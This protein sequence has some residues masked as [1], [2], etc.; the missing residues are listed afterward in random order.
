MERH[1]ANLDRVNIVQIIRDNY[2]ELN[3]TNKKIADFILQNLEMATFSPLLE[4]SKEIGVSDTSLIRFSRELGFKGYQDLRE[5][6]VDHIRKIIYPTLK[7]SI[8]GEQGQHP[9]IDVVMKKDMEYITKTMT[10]IDEK[11]FDSL[12]EFIM[13]AKRVFCMG[14]A[15]S[16]FLA[17]YLA[18]IL[19]FLSFE[20]IPV[21]RERRPMIQQILFM[22]KDDILIAFDLLPYAAEVLEAIEYIR[23]KDRDIRIVTI[24]NDPL[25]HIVQYSDLSFFCDMSGHEF[26]LASLTAPMCL[27]NAIMEQIA[28]KKPK[29]VNEAFD[30]FQRAIMSSPLHYAQFDPQNF[31]WRISRGK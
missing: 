3:E 26:K 31:Q 7:S 10:K 11:G 16:S 8:L 24:T 20:A 18:Y 12:I 19:R 5:S 1:A 2:P 9:F 29:R 13:A 17:E 23:N 15:C 4:I 6:L 14:W 30:E 27:I 22:D 25:A 28:A 21:I